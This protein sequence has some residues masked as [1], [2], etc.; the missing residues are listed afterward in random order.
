MAN[1]WAA[2]AELGVQ[3]T[4]AAMAQHKE[5]ER[6]KG[7]DAEQYQQDKRDL[8]KYYGQQLI[9]EQ[10]ATRY[11][12]RERKYLE[13]YYNRYQSPEAMARQYREA[14]FN[15]Y[16]AL[17]AESPFAVAAGANEPI[18]LD[19]SSVLNAGVSRDNTLASLRQQRSQQLQDRFFRSFEMAANMA[20]TY[21]QLQ[22][23]NEDVRAKRIA[24]DREEFVN[25][26]WSSP[27]SDEWI[28]LVPGMDE[29]SHSSTSDGPNIGANNLQALTFGQALQMAQAFETLKN[30]NEKGAGY[31]SN[32][33]Q[34]P[35]SNYLRSVTTQYTKHGRDWR[36]LDLRDLSG[37]LYAPWRSAFDV[38]HG[39]NLSGIS[40]SEY[41][42]WYNDWQKEL[43]K[44]GLNPEGN[45][46]LSTALRIVHST[47]PKDDFDYM[48]GSL[49]KGLGLAASG[50]GDI[51]NLIDK[52]DSFIKPT[53]AYLRSRDKFIRSYRNHK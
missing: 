8:W 29:L 20:S 41:Q 7:K 6:L 16:S 48:M 37:D 11:T 31:Y 32:D 47:T 38:V 1:P 46:L 49:G 52:L 26:V 10:F 36:D 12:D 27:I 28:S 25:R 42:R 35:W 44:K 33:P 23:L 4:Q 21:G 30:L 24:N 53:D 22:N 3:Y 50:I 39:T 40:Q 2:I 45:D 18:S 5:N 19:S 51:F 14:G 13:D 17:G 34:T 43:R 9:N 15:P